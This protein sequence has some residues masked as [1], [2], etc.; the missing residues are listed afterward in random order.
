MLMLM[1]LSLSSLSSREKDEK[2][3]APVAMPLIDPVTMS[4]TATPKSASKTPSVSGKS[5]TEPS[6]TPAVQV[7]ST[8]ASQ[9][10]RHVVPV[11]LAALFYGAFGFLVA[12]P[13]ATL[14]TSLPVVALLQVLY[15]FICLPLAGSGAGPGKNRKQRPGEK[16]KDGAGPNFV[17]VLLLPCGRVC[18]VGLVSVLIDPCHRRPLSSP[19]FSPCS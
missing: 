18:L 7:N 12:D 1:L 17:I 4:G 8:A 11:L 6:Q 14:W 13:V 5:T 15:A 2:H 19:S 10:A 3:E 9:A 16:R